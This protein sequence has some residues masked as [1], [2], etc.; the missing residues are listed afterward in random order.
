MLTDIA[1]SFFMNLLNSNWTFFAS[2][3]QTFSHIV[4]KISSQ[5]ELWIYQ[6][7]GKIWVML[8]ILIFELDLEALYSCCQTN[9]EQPTQKT[10]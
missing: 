5:S 8:E 10:S 9:T 3:F 2:E 4:F 1:N 7:M 6:L